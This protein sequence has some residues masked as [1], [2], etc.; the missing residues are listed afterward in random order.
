MSRP[1]LAI[2]TIILI[3]LLVSC[4]PAAPQAGVQPSSVGE[5]PKPARVVLAIGAEIDNLSTKLGGGTN[6]AEYNFMSSS[7]LALR[8]AQ[9][10]ARPLLAVELP[11]RDK[12]TWVV[13][14]DGTMR[15][16][17]KIKPNALWH[18]GQPVTAQDFAFAHRVALDPA[19]P[20]ANR[21]PEAFMDRVE[22]LDGNTFVIHW[23]RTYPWAN[24]L[25]ARDLE[26]LPV[27]I[28]GAVYEAADSDAFLNHR[29]WSS[30]DYVGTGPYMLVQW[31]PGAQLV[32]RAFEK[33]FMG[34]PKIDEVVFRII[35]D[36]NT[37]LASLLA[38][39]VHTS[40]GATALGQQAGA[41]LKEQWEQEGK[42]TV[43]ITPVRFRHTQLQFNPSYSE[44]SALLDPRVRR[45]IAHGINREELARVVTAGLSGPT[46]I[47]LSPTDPLYQQAQQVIARY[48]HDPNRALGLLQEA[49]WTKD[50]SGAVTDSRGTR[51]KLDIRS[52]QSTDNQTELSIMAADLRTLGMEITETVVPQSRIRDSEYRIKFPGLN[53]TALSIE[54]PDTLRRGVAAE[55]PDPARRYSGGN[56]GCWTNEEFDRF[57]LVASTSLDRAERGNAMVQALK[58]LTEDVGIIGLTYNSENIPVP[59]GL[60]GPGPRWPGQVGNTWNIHEW[61]WQ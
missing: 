50:P 40:V 53:N 46:E 20:V 38:G 57:Y 60:V 14:A 30:P 31:E 28:M 27:H 41:T 3:I 25:I 5:T 42:G 2:L 18:D 49:G 34:R 37:M 7:P 4:R 9:G 13:N 48:P 11:S 26:P 23:N 15:T 17:W 45:A 6:A 52:T 35:P 51:F 36:T 33:Y 8:D 24:E 43:V 39:D 12:G 29:F 44:Q 47:F 56:R 58:I 22:S 61:R 10:I 19:M 55:C 16:T 32:Y 54:I 21:N 59:K 1:S